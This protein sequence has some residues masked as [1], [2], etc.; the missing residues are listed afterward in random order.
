MLEMTG[1]AT[2]TNICV[3]LSYLELQAMHHTSFGKEKHYILVLLSY[4]LE[5]LQGVKLTWILLS[6][7]L[8]NWVSIVKCSSYD[9]EPSFSDITDMQKKNNFMFIKIYKD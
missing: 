1:G 4:S 9:L 2:H 6:I 7:N 3:F 8:I 5:Q